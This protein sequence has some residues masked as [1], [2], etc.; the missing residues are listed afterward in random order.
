MFKAEQA[1]A[2]TRGLG[3]FKAKD[4]VNKGIPREYLKRLEDKGKLIRS[5]RGVYTSVDA[6]FTENHSLVEA[7]QRKPGGVICLL[8]A[9]SFYELTTQAPFE[10]W[11]AIGQNTHAPKDNLLPLRVVYMSDRSLGAG[12]DEHQL[13]GVTVSVYSLAKTIADC[14]KYRHKVGL[15][16]ALEALQEC[17]RER[18]CSF[19]EIWHYAEICRVRSVMRPYLN[20]ALPLQ[21]QR[22]LNG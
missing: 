4:V 22:H 5:A 14:F 20:C 10:V 19:D 12:I 21:A 18:R 13:E 15:D 9:L 8:S 7:T 2:Y 3:A 1:L 16:V 6:E 17:L 11:M